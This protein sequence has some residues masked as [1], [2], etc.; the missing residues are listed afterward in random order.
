MNAAIDI[1]KRWMAID[2]ALGSLDGLHIASFAKQWE[3]SERTV[4][5]DLEAFQKLGEE[6]GHDLD[7]DGHRHVWHYAGF[8]WMF[9]ANVPRRARRK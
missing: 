3:V 8:G 1:L 2:K 4:R 5:R 7:A 6:I 9:T